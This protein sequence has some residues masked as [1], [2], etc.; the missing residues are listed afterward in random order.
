MGD[1]AIIPASNYL[2]GNNN[3]LFWVMFGLILFLTNIIFLNF[4]IAEAG[5]SYSQVAES[6]KQFQGK[7]KSYLISE[8]ETMIPNWI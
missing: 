3:I 6:L 7:A 2:D 1:Y 8:S 5:N 4:V